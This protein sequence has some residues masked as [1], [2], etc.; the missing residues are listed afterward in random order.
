MGN[1]YILDNKTI[2]RIKQNNCFDFLRYFFALSLI[3]VHFCTLTE[4]EQFWFISG[5]MRV[6]AFFTITGFLVVYSY[7]RRGNIKIY[8]IK[9]VRRILP[10]Y[11]TTILFCF[12]IGYFFS[13]ESYS[14]YFFSIQSI[15]YL[16]ANLTFLNFIE[17]CLPGLFSNNPVETS[18][19]GS[20]WSMKYEVIFYILVP[21]I[22]WLIKKYHKAYI[23]ITIISLYI[24]FHA[25][26]DYL[27]F[28]TGNLFY[29]TVNNSSPNT[30]IYFITGT[31]ILLYFDWFYKNIKY[32]IISCAIFFVFLEISEIDFLYYIEP[33]FFSSFII[34][35]AYYVKPLYFLRKY[36][37]ISYGLY[38]FHYP[39]IQV[40]IQY[41]LHIYN[42]YLTFILA[43]I[44]TIFLALIS[45]YIIEKPLLNKKT[46]YH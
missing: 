46:C 24:G 33:I 29:H 20:L 12:I 19:N 28:R 6:K 9:R 21:F 44:I 18:V 23:I 40:L 25:I 43:L 42:I 4:T 27:E 3:L 2:E 34:G 38:L 7:I 31:F 39:V 35:F 30:M 16:I 5:Q 15:K 26:L 13:F 17:P 37:N 8:F 11:I 10:A 1:K 36:D 32:I 22:I 41:Q 14:E 45:W